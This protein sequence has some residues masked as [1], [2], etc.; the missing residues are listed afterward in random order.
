MPKRKKFTMTQEQLDTIMAA[1]KPVPMIMLQCGGPRSPQENVNF[2]WQSLG[3]ELGFKCDT[4]QPSGSDQ[5]TFTAEIIEENSD[6]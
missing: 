3:K 2:A 6:A 1:C 4:V 5:K